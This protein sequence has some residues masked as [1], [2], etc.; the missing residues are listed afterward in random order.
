MGARQRGL[1]S[2]VSDW[3]PEDPELDAVIAQLC[4][5]LDQRPQG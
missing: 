3:E 5:E 2:L 1:E 4:E